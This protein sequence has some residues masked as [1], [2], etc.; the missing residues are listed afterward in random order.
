MAAGDLGQQLLQ[1]RPVVRIVLRVVDADVG[2]ALL[3]VR[4][5]VV[6][7]Q[8]LAVAL[9]GGIEGR[10][11]GNGAHAVLHLPARQ[12]PAEREQCVQREAGVFA[13]MVMDQEGPQVVRS[14]HHVGVELEQVLRLSP[15][16]RCKGAGLFSCDEFT[17]HDDLLRP[18]DP[19]VRVTRRRRAFGE[20]VPLLFLGF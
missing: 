4:Q 10:I 17:E 1:H 6:E 16:S 3:E 7:V 5:H 12:S 9:V 15:R 20:R 13:E 14:A 18:T 8:A 19:A 2:V 11:A